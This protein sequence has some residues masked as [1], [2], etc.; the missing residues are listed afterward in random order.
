MTTTLLSSLT[1]SRKVSIGGAARWCHETVC[2]HC[3][4]HLVSS[5]SLGQQGVRCGRKRGKALTLLYAAVTNLWD[6]LPLLSRHLGGENGGANRD[7]WGGHVRA[8]HQKA[9]QVQ[10]SR[11]KG[12]SKGQHAGSL[13]W[14]QRQLNADASLC[15]VTNVR[16]A[17][18]LLSRYLGMGGKCVQA[19]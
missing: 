7:N 13:V 4:L 2:C 19:G 10:G 14:M 3:C 15:A 18:P 5:S 12:H 8:W 17:L 11:A 9:E 16:D 1:D 6:A